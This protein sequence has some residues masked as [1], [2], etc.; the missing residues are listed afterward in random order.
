MIDAFAGLQKRKQI[1]L[2]ALKLFLLFVARRDNSM[3][4]AL[5]RYDQIED[6]SGISRARIKPALSLLCAMGLIQIEHL[7][8][9][10]GEPGMASGYRLTHIDSQRHMGTIGRALDPFETGHQEV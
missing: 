10:F 2:D 4:M 3:N 8:R 6:R 9:K 7:P 1:E 5:L